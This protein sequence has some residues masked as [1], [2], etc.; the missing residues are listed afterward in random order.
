MDTIAMETIGHDLCDMGEFGNS[1]FRDRDVDGG[2]C[3][4]LVEKPDVEL[5]NR[6]YSWDLIGRMISASGRLPWEHF[7]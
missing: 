6:N 3:L 4:F 7:E 5:V 2:H 1:L